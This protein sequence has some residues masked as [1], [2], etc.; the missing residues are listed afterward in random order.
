MSDWLIVSIVGS[1]VLTVLLNLL[2][3]LF[4]KTARRAQERMIEE[5]HKQHDWEDDATRAG[6]SVKV[7]FPWKAMLVGSLV[8]TV[9][10]N[11][12]GWFAR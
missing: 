8:L 7:F 3:M 9:L 4:P 2:P 5:I 1:V 12:I 6:P 10:I 11:L